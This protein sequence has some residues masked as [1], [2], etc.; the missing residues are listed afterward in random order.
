MFLPG[1][2]A[3]PAPV[4]VR[5]LTATLGHSDPFTSLMSDS[6]ITQQVLRMATT[7]LSHNIG[8][9][10]VKPGSVTDDRSIASNIIN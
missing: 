1:V 6:I 3:N 8:K 9:D 2:L 7:T 4:R 10:Q 5:K